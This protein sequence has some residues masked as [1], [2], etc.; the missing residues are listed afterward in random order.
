MKQEWNANTVRLNCTIRA[1]IKEAM[2]RLAL[3][4]NRIEGG[5]VGLG[6]VLGEAAMML[7]EKEGITLDDPSAPTVPGFRHGKPPKSAKSLIKRKRTAVA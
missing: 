1:D 3:K 2:E 6:R 7:L 5:Y 4:R